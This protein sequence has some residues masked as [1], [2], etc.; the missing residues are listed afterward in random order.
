MNM[1]YDVCV[2]TYGVS[3]LESMVLGGPVDVDFG[4]GGRGNAP[5]S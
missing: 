5:S 4:I 1:N 3:N 2:L